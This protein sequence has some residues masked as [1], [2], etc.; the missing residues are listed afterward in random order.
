MKEKTLLFD[1]DTWCKVGVWIQAPK[2]QHLQ[3]MWLNA[4]WIAEVLKYSTKI[5]LLQ[6][7]E[8]AESHLRLRLIA[9]LVLLTV[10]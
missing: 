3:Y 10:I 6:K 9:S 5:K 2:S 7:M 1:L 8:S 4:S